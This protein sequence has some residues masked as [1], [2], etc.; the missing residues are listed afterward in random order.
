MIIAHVL[1]VLCKQ[2]LHCG[3]FNP[4]SAVVGLE[5]YFQG[6]TPFK[7]GID[8]SSFPRFNL[9]CVMCL[10]YADPGAPVSSKKD[11]AVEPSG[12]TKLSSC[13]VLILVSDLSH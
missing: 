3:G 1:I 4:F 7:F 6:R 8:I 2:A 11:H 5:H 12:G 10:L 9:T 13:R